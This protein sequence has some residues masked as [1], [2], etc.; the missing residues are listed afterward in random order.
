MTLL[1]DTHV[2]VWWL[3]GH[4]LPHPAQTEAMQRAEKSGEAFGLSAISLWELAR[5]IEKKRLAI[6]AAPE[7][8]FEQIEGHPQ[9]ELLPLTPRI[10]LE[11]SR[12][13]SEFSKDPADR[14]IAA[15]ARVHGLRLVTAD[16]TLRRSSAIAV[17]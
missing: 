16:E 7:V 17:V 12:L 11:A 3:L 4:P 10:A 1:L 5:L 2:L 14:I 9:L 13:G 6:R 15:T 8:L